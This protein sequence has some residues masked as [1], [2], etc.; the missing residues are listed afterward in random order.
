LSL[1]YRAGVPVEVGPDFIV[2]NGKDKYSSVNVKT[3]EYPGFATDLQAPMTVFLT[4]AKG[5]S[6]VFETIFDGRL[7]YVEDLIRMGADI[8]IFDPHRVL[9][10]GPREL[11]GRELVGPDLRAGLAFLIAAIIADGESTLSNI[12]FIDRGYEN[13]EGRLQNIGVAIE[14]IRA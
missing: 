11:K 4:Q 12:H 13:I 3:H 5:E 1:L 10:R 7:H 14:R 2:V 8:T 6:L 9:I